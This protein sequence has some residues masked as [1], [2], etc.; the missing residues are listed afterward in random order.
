[1]TCFVYIG[2]LVFR[3]I[4]L[5]L[6]EI[7]RMRHMRVYLSSNP[8]MLIIVIVVRSIFVFVR[9]YM[10]GDVS[11]D[12]FKLVMLLF[13]ILMVLILSSCNI[14]IFLRWEGIGVMS[15][16]LIRYWIRPNGKS[17]AISAIMYNR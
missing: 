1:M 6:L 5:I 9:Y 11:N 14:L 4:L 10:R 16:I 17:G 3:L 12:N 15:I 2:N 13:L 8:L 7:V